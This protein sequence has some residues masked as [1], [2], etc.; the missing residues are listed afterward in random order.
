MTPLDT[1][2]PALDTVSNGLN[3]IIPDV[4]NA[5]SNPTDQT[6]VKTLIGG[7]ILYLFR[8]IVKAI[9]NRRSRHQNQ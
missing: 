5:I 9:V 2:Q 4:V 1:I 8:L 3:A 7:G 6:A